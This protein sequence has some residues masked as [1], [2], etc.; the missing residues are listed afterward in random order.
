MQHDLITWKHR[1]SKTIQISKGL[2]S[3][4]FQFSLAKGNILRMALL[5]TKQ[6][7]RM[8]GRP[9][10]VN[11]FKKTRMTNQL[12]MMPLVIEILENKPVRRDKAAKKGVPTNKILR[13][14]ETTIGRRVGGEGE[15]LISEITINPIEENVFQ[16]RIR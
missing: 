1:R 6:P 5:I 9:D 16:D 7:K 14:A 15:G 13:K 8:E 10:G 11:C 4:P 3:R 2:I 12:W